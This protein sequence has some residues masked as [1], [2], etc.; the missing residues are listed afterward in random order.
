LNSPTSF[1]F[2]HDDSQGRQNHVFLQ[3][4][5][6]EAMDSFQYVVKLVI[7]RNLI[8]LDAAYN[9]EWSHLLFPPGNFGVE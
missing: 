7:H 5:Q 4:I 8:S 3:H 6:G 9:G 1:L 2:S